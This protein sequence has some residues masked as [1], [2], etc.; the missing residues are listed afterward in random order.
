MYRYA[1]KG[2]QPFSTGEPFWLAQRGDDMILAAAFVASRIMPT[3]T[4]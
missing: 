2:A 4:H 1:Q 3:S